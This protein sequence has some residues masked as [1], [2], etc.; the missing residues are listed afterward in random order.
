VEVED[1]AL[2]NLRYH[3]GALGT[4]E[5]S[6]C[7]FGVGQFPIE[8]PEDA[9]MGTDGHLQLGSNLK[10]FD[11]VRFSRQFE[12]QKLSVTDLKI[13]LLE[14][15]ARHLREGEPLR[16]QPADAVHALKLI[17]AAYASAARGL[18][19]SLGM[20]RAVSGPGAPHALE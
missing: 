7:T 20:E 13:G 18:P 3:S 16:S 6:C 4:I 19:V 11:R 12:F 1:F 14:N 5:A 15:F 2:V 10:C 8:R 17:E 9:I